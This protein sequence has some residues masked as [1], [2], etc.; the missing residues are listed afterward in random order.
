MYGGKNVGI[1]KKR[2]DK[3]K[4][5]QKHFNIIITNVIIFMCNNKYMVL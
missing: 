2:F 3:K 5:K 1:R 4:Q